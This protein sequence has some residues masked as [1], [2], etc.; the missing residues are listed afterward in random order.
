MHKC[1]YCGQDIKEGVLHIPLGEI[2]VE[3]FK[4]KT[5]YSL[6]SEIKYE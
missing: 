5:C 1:E 3:D 6:K 4:M 2:E